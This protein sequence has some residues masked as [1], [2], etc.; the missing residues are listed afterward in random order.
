MTSKVRFTAVRLAV[1]I[2]LS[3]GSVL[4]LT[5]PALA[6]PNNCS[7]GISYNIV[8]ASKFW[9]AWGKCTSGT[10]YYQVHAV[11]YEPGG[12]YSFPAGPVLRV[13][14]GQSRVACVDWHKPVDRWVTS[15]S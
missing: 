14:Q 15:W 13:G 1:V 5:T 4:A 6:V 2:V 8:G 11:C 3:F 9:Y 10:G 7:S 12:G